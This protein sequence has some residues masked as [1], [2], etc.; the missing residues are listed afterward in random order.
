MEPFPSRLAPPPM[1]IPIVPGFLESPQQEVPDFSYIEFYNNPL[2]SDVTIIAEDISFHAHRIILHRSPFFSALLNSSMKEVQPP[3]PND[4]V[5]TPK[6]A[7]KT[8][9]VTLQDISSSCVEAFLRFLYGDSLQDLSFDECI[10]LYQETASFLTLKFTQTIWNLILG[11][12]RQGLS[13]SERVSLIKLAM[14]YTIEL[15]PIEAKDV[16]PCVISQLSIDS[17]LYL[18][19]RIEKHMSWG[20]VFTWIAS[21][22]QATDSNVADLLNRCV[23]PQISRI[24]I[25]ILTTYRSVPILQS[26]I[27]ETMEKFLTRN[28]F[29]MPHSP[30]PFIPLP[31][32]ELIVIIKKIENQE[33]IAESSTISQ[34]HLV[35]KKSPMLKEEVEIRVIPMKN[36]PGKY[37]LV[38][39]NLVVKQIDDKIILVG[40]S[41]FDDHIISP[42]ISDIREA[43][44]MGIIMEEEQME[45]VD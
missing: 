18:F 34:S 43:R 42:N 38:N 30:N 35:K 13:F 5:S 26:F 23:I 37:K 21:H 28:D 11:H 24:D 15:P 16:H 41:G 27:I 9:I 19:S 44:S 17:M 2:Y 6:S 36:H 33:K 7:V 45:E 10:I 1:T 4:E 8:A 29:P 20:P 40:I 32:E 25:K 14:T 39:S 3:S 31:Y 12:H 22:P